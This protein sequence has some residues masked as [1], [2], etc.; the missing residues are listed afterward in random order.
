MTRLE[1]K[2]ANAIDDYLAAHPRVK[3]ST[4]TNAM[5]SIGR[6]LARGVR[7]KAKKKG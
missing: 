3:V 1:V 5:E 7:N 4:I 6:K 2:I